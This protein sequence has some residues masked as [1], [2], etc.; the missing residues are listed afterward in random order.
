MSNSL[1]C[2]VLTIL[3]WPMATHAQIAGTL[4]TTPLPP[5]LFA[6]LTTA[7]EAYARVE[8]YNDVARV[9]TRDP[10]CRRGDETLHQ[11]LRDAKVQLGIVYERVQRRPFFPVETD[12]KRLAAIALVESE[13]PKRIA[14]L[15]NRL[16][17]LPPEGVVACQIRTQPQDPAL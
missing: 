7:E 17:R 2:I 14:Q 5:N 16:E 15:R 9:Q 8:A 10:R 4:R 3:L 1:R 13:Y 6:L 11:L 12:G